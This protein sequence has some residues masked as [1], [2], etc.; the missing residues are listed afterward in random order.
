[1][2]YTRLEKSEKTEISTTFQGV[3]MPPSEK[4]SKKCPKANMH[5]QLLGK[6]LENKELRTVPSGTTVPVPELSQI[7][8]S[9]P[10][11][12]GEGSGT[13]G[14]KDHLVGNYRQE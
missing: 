9:P 12:G 3:Q 13:E 10:F 1:M 14:G 8:L 7:P 2:N 6:S 4:V 11:R 5:G